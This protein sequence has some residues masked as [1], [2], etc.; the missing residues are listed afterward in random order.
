MA[1]EKLYSAL[2][3]LY[4]LHGVEMDEDTFETFALAAY[5]MIGNHDYRIY[6]IVAHPEKDPEGGWFIYKPCNMD[7]IEAITLSY[8]SAQEKSAVSNVTGSY[9]HE[10]EQ[11][12]ELGKSM[13]NHLYIPGKF[14]K[15]RELGDKIYFTEPF[16]SVNVLYKG[17]YAD[18]DGL[19]YI[20]EKEKRAIVAYC[21]YAYDQ[22]QGRLT[23]DQSTLNMAQLEYQLWQ[24]ACSEARTPEK[25]SQNTMNEILD[26][27][28]T[29]N[30]H[31]YG[32][33]STKPMQ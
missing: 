31:N 5:N 30:V 4:D 7:E 18:E 26:A 17:Y 2:S 24:K 33:S 28:S 20:N 25:I 15:Y 23:K 12:I 21:L 22:K 14:V 9:T 19:P 29:W 1:K 13:P 11:W 8:E 27:M 32:S 3:L 6:R 16:D 10:I